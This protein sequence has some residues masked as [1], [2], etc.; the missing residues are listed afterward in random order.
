MGKEITIKSGVLWGVIALA[1]L[2][3][4]L[5]VG[6]FLYDNGT[7][8]LGGDDPRDYASF[9]PYQEVLGTYPEK[10]YEANDVHIDWTYDLAQ[11]ILD[12]VYLEDEIVKAKGRFYRDGKWQSVTFVLVGPLDVEVG[13][14]EELL[15]EGLELTFSPYLT[16]YE[17]SDELGTVYLE[18]LSGEELLDTL[19]V[20]EQIGIEYI[21]N[22]S[23]TVTLDALCLDNFNTVCAQ[24]KISEHY[25]PI[26]EQKVYLEEGDVVYVT[27]LS[28]ALIGER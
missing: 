6:Y 21:R 24:I 12:E 28:K 16:Q 18:G 19:K 26:G 20:S 8:Y 14:T 13:I 4:S 11:P 7:I 23:T 5:T 10:S 27:R 15:A 9:Y 22:Y 3:Y 2:L 25:Q 1:L 17:S